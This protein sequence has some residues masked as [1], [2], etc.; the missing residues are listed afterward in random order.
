MRIVPK[1]PPSA[2]VNWYK[3]IDVWTSAGPIKE[4]SVTRYLCNLPQYGGVGDSPLFWQSII[5]AGRAK[6]VTWRGDKISGATQCFYGKGSPDDVEYALR[7][8]EDVAEAALD[9]PALKPFRSIL[10]DEDNRLATVC[11]KYIGVDCNGFVGNYGKENA[12]PR[13][14]PNLVPSLWKNV[15]P[16]DQ[17]RSSVDAISPLDVLIWPHGAHIAIIDSVDNG[18]F[19]ICQS[20]GGGGP[21]TS[22]RHTITAAG[23]TAE[24]DPQ[25]TVS[26]GARDDGQRPPTLPANVR[27]KAIGF[28]ITNYPW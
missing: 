3:A 22:A 10:E 7:V 25:F 27:I 23:K 13:A 17:W 21:Q 15:G 28:E 6:Q 2:F 11:E 24:G 19:T 26:G 1:I 14:D 4:A 9:H 12:L 18:L 20:T 8:V 5:Q 16:I